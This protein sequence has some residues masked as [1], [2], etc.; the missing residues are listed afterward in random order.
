[1]RFEDWTFREAEVR[2]AE[3]SDPRRAHGLERVPDQT[4]LYRFMRL[5]YRPDARRGAHRRRESASSHG[6]EAASGSRR[7]SP[8]TLQGSV[9]TFFINRRAD[10]GEGLTWRHWCKWT[11]VADVLRRCVLS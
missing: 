7:W 6:A 3:H 5:A 2:L 8:S 1:M 4:T 10:R 11:V 9:S